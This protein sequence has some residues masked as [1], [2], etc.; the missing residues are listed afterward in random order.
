MLGDL[1]ADIQ[2]FVF[3]E[4]YHY[5]SL[6]M[7]PNFRQSLAILSETVILLL[8]FIKSRAEKRKKSIE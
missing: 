2:N 5:T 8:F 7:P 1:D 4:I 3:V 6:C